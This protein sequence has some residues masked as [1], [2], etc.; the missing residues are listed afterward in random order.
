MQS[1][2]RTRQRC[3]WPARELAVCVS[4]LVLEL[5]VREGAVPVAEI[6]PAGPM[7]GNLLI[8]KERYVSC[9]TLVEQA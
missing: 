6:F 5:A 7:T 2:G 8:E 4:V 1:C 9:A 3:A